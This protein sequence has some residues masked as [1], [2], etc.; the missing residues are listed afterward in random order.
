MHCW[1][2]KPSRFGLLS[3]VGSVPA[4]L[5]LNSFSLTSC[6]ASD[7]VVQ[8]I[9]KELE[10]LEPSQ[11]LSLIRGAVFESPQLREFGEADF[12]RHHGFLHCLR[13]PRGH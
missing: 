13:R 7:G 8:T 1:Y 12:L 6:V 11:F 2:P 9:P 10:D 3:Q 4:I 5:R